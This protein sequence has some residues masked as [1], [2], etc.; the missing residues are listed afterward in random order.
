MATPSKRP[1]GRRSARQ[2]VD[3]GA[4][5]K[6]AGSLPGLEEG[7]S[8]GTPAWR[9]RKKLV[10]RLREDG[11]TLV[12][13]L[14]FDLK[15]L[16]LQADP[17]VFFT[18]DHYRKHASVLVRLPVVRADRLAELLEDAWRRAAPKTVV[19]AYDAART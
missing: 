3:L 8:Y 1:S 15:E 17:A 12:V 6:L 5:R 2:G 16:L 14:D 19:S 13:L 7:T 4:L 10:A 9:V 18:T 11:E